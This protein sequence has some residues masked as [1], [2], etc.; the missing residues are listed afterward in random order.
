MAW[1]D[2]DDLGLWLRCTRR[3]ALTSLPPILFAPLETEGGENYGERH[4]FPN[5]KSS[6]RV[7]P[8]TEARSASTNTTWNP[9]P[10]WGRGLVVKI[11]MTSLLWGGT[12]DE[13]DLSVHQGLLM[14]M[15]EP[16]RKEDMIKKEYLEKWRR[17]MKKQNLKSKEWETKR[18]WER[19]NKNLKMVTIR[20]QTS[21]LFKVEADSL[22]TGG[23]WNSALKF[24]TTI[25]LHSPTHNIS[26]TCHSIT[27][28]YAR[29]LCVSCTR[30]QQ[31]TN[32]TFVFNAFSNGQK[33]VKLPNT[34]T[35]PT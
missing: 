9:W 26:S 16:E 1:G 21:T 19:D 4:K 6:R 17:R 33:R 32:K 30:L 5:R 29:V 20:N 13:D 2:E 34:G 24:H 35:P 12:A 11:P 25:Q 22:V 28:T 31:K 27:D 7:C 8:P 15:A 10:I 3:D 23:S 14:P 18:F